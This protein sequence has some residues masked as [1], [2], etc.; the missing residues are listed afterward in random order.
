MSL[1]ERFG[2]ERHLPAPLAPLYEIARNLWWTW[3]AEATRLMIELD[4]VLWKN[5]RHNPL[6]VIEALDAARVAALAADA[7][8]TARLA[9]VRDRQRAYLGSGEA[10]IDLDFGGRQIGYFCAEFGIHESLPIYSGGLGILA[11]DHLKAASDR[12][13]PLVAVGLAYRYGYFHQEVDLAGRQH[14]VYL[15]NDF[16]RLPMALVHDKHGD[17]LTLSLPYPGRKLLACVWKVSVGRI[18]L[19]LL[20]T[21]L[22]GNNAEDR[23]ITGH[24]YGGN[25]DTRVRQEFL[26]G[27]GGLRALRA[28]GIAPAVCHLNEGHSSF[29][30]LEQLRRHIVDGSQTF[31]RAVA[32]VRAGCVFTTHTPVPAGNDNFEVAHVMQ[33]LRPLAAGM[34]EPVERL[35]ALGLTDPANPHERFEMTVLALRL[36]RFAN[37]VSALHGEVSRGMWRHLW[38]ERT[39]AQVPITSVTNGV[40]MPTWIA[41]EIENL[42]LGAGAGSP[43]PEQIWRVHEHLRSE[44]IDGVRR[45]LQRQLTRNGAPAPEIADVDRVFDPHT[46]TIGFARR[47]AEYKRATL[48]MSD[49]DRFVRLLTNA[50]RPVQVLMAGKAHPR[51]EPGKLLIQRVWELSRIPALRGRLVVLEGYDIALARRMVQGADIWLNTPRRP[52][53]A[54]GTSGMKAAANGALNLSVLDGWWCE[55]YD[56]RN[57]WAFGDDHGVD[58]ATQDARDSVELFELL[59]KV[60]VPMFYDRGP[61]GL[62]RAWIQRMQHAMSTVVPRFSSER[63]VDEYAGRFYLPCA[64]DD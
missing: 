17:P 14:E 12:D 16:E 50:D 41:P 1:T 44:L 63:M 37:G 23:N 33:Y 56:G 51:S 36:S 29:L 38:P 52:L 28:M 43:A 55:G 4:P 49:P 9:A 61:D 32:S 7:D 39:T 13:L 20:D 18:P 57:G 34:D 35:I 58:E 21:D 60:V 48:L 47:F 42:R 11:G 19:Y 25:E 27:V 31:E 5:G 62:P 54:S 26:L 3:D 46:L 45:R 59:E 24:L 6:A 15:A 22:P 40:H 53:E 10:P 64:M 2:P 8:F 30:C